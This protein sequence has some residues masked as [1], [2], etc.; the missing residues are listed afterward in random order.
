[1]IKPI[2]KP[3]IYGV[4][5]LAVLNALL[6][7]F[8]NTT[9]SLV[10][11][12]TLSAVVAMLLSIYLYQFFNFLPLFE[13]IDQLI[14]QQHKSEDETMLADQRTG[15]LIKRNQQVERLFS[16]IQRLLLSYTDTASHLS[17]TSSQ[18]AISAAKVSFSV[19]ELRN[20]LE[21]QAE[22]ISQVV[23][24]TQEI[25]KIGQCVANTSGIAKTFS[26]EVKTDSQN[27][28]EVLVNAYHKINEILLHTEKANERIILLSKNSDKIRDVTRA[29]EGIAKQTNLLALNAAIEAARAGE[30]GRG[31]A[32][33]ADEVRGL[34]ARTSEATREVG[35]II[36]LNH[37]ETGNVVELFNALI[38]EVRVGTKYIQNSKG[39]IQSVTIK[40]ADVENRIS[41]IADNAQKN[42]QH[43]QQISSSISTMDTELAQSRDHVRLLDIEA[44]K[45]SEIAERANA[46]LAELAIDGIHQNVF[47]IAQTA[48]RAIQQKFE[49]SIKT[50]EISETDL[51]DRVYKKIESSNPFKYHTKFDSYTDK[52]L[53]DIQ[54]KILEQNNFL[55]Y[56]IL[57]DDRG[58]VPTHNRRF[59]QPLSGNYE[60]DLSG[61]RSKRIF[62]D[63]TGS[64]CGGHTERLLLQTYKRDTGEV[65]HDLSVPIY[66]NGKHWGGFRVGYI[67]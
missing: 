55:A 33:V 4:I 6:F 37:T 19:S 42:H 14:K 17:R 12:F 54:E 32:V 3:F 28:Q 53:P 51:F 34:A 57:T 44:E 31:F 36:D 60:K 21:I 27:V 16:D 48:S 10:F 46:S 66:I 1:M 13:S 30:M 43:L 8:T 65:M 67:S 18:S 25:T 5:T 56:A 9:L 35:E 22:E 11:M 59:S 41:D 47:N 62:D 58:Y 7:W 52:V 2:F 49:T 61:N 20:K 26:S 24:S 23:T 45:L 39:V 15:K 63:K 38:E 64:R 40:V 50:G 29:I